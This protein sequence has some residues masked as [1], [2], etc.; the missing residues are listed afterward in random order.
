MESLELIKN[1]LDTRLGVEGDKV[2]PAAALADLGI[3]SLMLLELMFEFEDRFG[4]KL[5]QD[6]PAPR[7]VGDMATL[8][9][10]L[11]ASREG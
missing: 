7:T 9:D 6:L 5:S 11:I 3:D 4:I 10:G 8:M 2:V 1:F